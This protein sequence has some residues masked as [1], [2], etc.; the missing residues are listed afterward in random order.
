VGC[1]GLLDDRDDPH[2]GAALAAGQRVD[3]VDAA[4]QLCPPAPLL[5]ALSRLVGLGRVDIGR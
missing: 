5:A 2:R 1:R 3:L 4:E